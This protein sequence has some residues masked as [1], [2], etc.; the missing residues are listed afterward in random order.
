MHAK[1]IGFHEEE[2]NWPVWALGKCFEDFFF[3]NYNG[4]H[5]PPGEGPFSIVEFY[6]SPKT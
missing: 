3:L 6:T 5:L 2:K 1:K 4:P